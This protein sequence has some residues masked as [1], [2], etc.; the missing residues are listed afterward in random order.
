[1]SS[2]ALLGG[3][4]PECRSPQRPRELDF[5]EGAVGPSSRL[6][7]WNRKP[8]TYLPSLTRAFTAPVAVAIKACKSNTFVQYYM[9]PG[10]WALIFAPAGFLLSQQINLEAHILL[11]CE[12]GTE[13][14]CNGSLGGVRG[15]VRTMG[16]APA[17]FSTS[18]EDTLLSSPSVSPAWPPDTRTI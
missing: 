6:L 16:V 2:G 5:R 9:L 8:Q 7:R 17:L 3:A 11:M 10:V 1:M 18:G 13:M 4:R 15:A 14:T 12:H